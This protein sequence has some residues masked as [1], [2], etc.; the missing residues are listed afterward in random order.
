MFGTELFADHLFAMNNDDGEERILPT[1]V[2]QCPDTTEWND[3]D[4]DQVD[5]RRCQDGS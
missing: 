1:W 5:T 2:I 4:K 3:Q